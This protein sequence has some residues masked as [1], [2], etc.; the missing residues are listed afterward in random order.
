MIYC[1]K[2]GKDKNQIETSQVKTLS[3]N[4]EVVKKSNKSLSLK[5]SK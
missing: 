3:N 2:N 5:K 1:S 4:D